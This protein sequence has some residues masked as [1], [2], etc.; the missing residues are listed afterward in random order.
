M[1]DSEAVIELI[2]K[3]TEFNDIHSQITDEDLDTALAMIVKLIAKP[4]IPIGSA[5]RLV[6]S[7]QALSAKFAVLARYYTSFENKGPENSKKKN[8]YYTLASETDKLASAVKYLA[9]T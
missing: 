3:V 8:L 7:M 1:N 2:S 9:K 5:P 6:V 4:D